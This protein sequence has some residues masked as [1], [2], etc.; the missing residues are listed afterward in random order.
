VPAT[1]LGLL[2]LVA[3]LRAAG[4]SANVRPDLWLVLHLAGVVTAVALYLLA[5]RWAVWRWL[6]ALAATPALLLPGSAVPSRTSVPVLTV[7]ALSVVAVLL[8]WQGTPWRRTLLGGLGCLVAAAS[9]GALLGAAGAGPSSPRAL[10]V[11]VGAMAATLLL[12]VGCAGAA[13]CAA[14]AGLGRAGPSG[15]RTVT[16]AAVLLPCALAAGAA[17]TGTGAEGGRLAELAVLV[18]WPMAGAFGVTAV[19]RGRRG[20]ATIRAQLDEVDRQ[21][22]SDFDRR[23]STPRLAP[24]TVVIAA[25][26]EERGLPAVLATMP[27]TVCGLP[28][29]V[30]VVDD[31]SRDGTA[32][33]VERDPRALLVR[34]A[35][36]R[37]QGAALRLGY[38]V[39][40]EHGAR[41]LVTTDADGQYDTGDLPAVLAPVLEGRA[42]FVTGSRRLGRQHTYDVVRRTG[43]HVFAGIVSALV[44]ERITDTSFGLRAM[45][46]EVTAAVTL[47]QVQ[48]QSSELLI[49]VLSHGFGVLEVPATMHLR[50]AGASKKGRNLVYGRRY[51]GVVLGTWWREGCPRPAAESAPA[52]GGSDAPTPA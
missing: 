19:L 23:Y 43:V 30:L 6:A 29:D 49:G 47:N 5:R 16:A 1:L 4:L 13:G 32:A 24:V 22:L 8:L 3:V 33:V 41:F 26:E 11:P 31:G 28:T 7:L 38:R 12:A 46:A 2:V 51:A 14:V 20:R 18:W 35:A 37:G 50:T 27:R 34:G 45:R 52:L 39:A 42:D 36:N 15:L 17:A 44:G 48:Y 40:R 10:T 25:Y 21:A 9:V